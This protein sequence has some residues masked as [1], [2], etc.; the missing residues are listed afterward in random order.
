MLYGTCTLL[1]PPAKTENSVLFQKSTEKAEKQ[2]GVFK[3]WTEKGLFA[4]G[5]ILQNV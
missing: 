5:A 2:D 4:P 3:Q 1:R